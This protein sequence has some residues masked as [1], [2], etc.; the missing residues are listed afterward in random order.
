MELYCQAQPQ[1]QL[2]LSKVL[3]SLEPVT[4][5]PTSINLQEKFV[6]SEELETTRPLLAYVS[7]VGSY[8]LRIILFY[9]I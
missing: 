8:Y 3:F 5:Q 1:L 6:L 4:H 7:F 2:R 9:L